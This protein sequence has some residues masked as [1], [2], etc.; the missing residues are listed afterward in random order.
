MTLFGLK[1]LK[2]IYFTIKHKFHSLFEVITGSTLYKMDYTAV[3]WQSK[4]DF[5]HWC[6]KD[7]PHPKL[8]TSKMLNATYVI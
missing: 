6:G 3:V 5:C 7:G 4:L 1:S 2:G 8:Q